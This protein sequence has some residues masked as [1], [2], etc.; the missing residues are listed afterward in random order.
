MIPI[1]KNQEVSQ[2]ALAG[3]EP[4]ARVLSRITPLGFY[5]RT[6]FCNFIRVCRIAPKT[7]RAREREGAQEGDRA[8]GGNMMAT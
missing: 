3:G 8:I 5:P 2:N 7:G 6:Q 1:K 4:S